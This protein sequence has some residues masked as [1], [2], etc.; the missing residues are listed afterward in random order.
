MQGTFR[1]YPLPADG[2]EPPPRMLQN[3]PSNETVEL[4]VRIYVIK[5]KDLQ[6]QDPNGFVSDRNSHDVAIAE[7][8]SLT[9]K[10]RFQR[11]FFSA[12]F[13][14]NIIKHVLICLFS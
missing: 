7:W 11:N 2:S 13:S 3:A 12:V 6:P 4:K 1:I 10:Y 8:S 5:A 9:I 14:S